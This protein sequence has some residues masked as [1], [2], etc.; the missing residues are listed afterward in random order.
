MQTKVTHEDRLSKK[1]SD[2]EPEDKSPVYVL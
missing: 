2:T 1:W